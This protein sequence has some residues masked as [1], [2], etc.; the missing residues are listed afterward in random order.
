MKIKFGLLV[1]KKKK[2]GPRVIFL[3]E[4]WWR[5]CVV[6]FCFCSFV[7]FWEE[8]SVCPGNGAHGQ[9]VLRSNNEICREAVHKRQETRHQSSA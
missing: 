4:K 7:V 9:T 3:G 1:T 2:E 6:V 8:D 5:V